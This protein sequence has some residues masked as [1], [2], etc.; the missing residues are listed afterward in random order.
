MIHGNLPQEILNQTT[1]GPVSSG[2]MP[3]ALSISG[4]SGGKKAAFDAFSG[5]SSLDEVITAV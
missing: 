4:G 3:N 1:C 5:E 2:F